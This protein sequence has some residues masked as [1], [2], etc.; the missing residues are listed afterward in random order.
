MENRI[1]VSKRRLRAV[2]IIAV[3]FV[4]LSAAI[5][6]KSGEID[7]LDSDATWHTLLTIEAYNETPIT[8]HLFLP[9]ISLG[10][11]TDKNI[12]WGATVSDRVGNYY[13]T[14]F[15]PA[16]YFLPWL[17]IKCFRLGVTEKSLYVFNTFLL[18]L[19]TII[20]IR[21]LSRVYRKSKYKELLC[22]V[23]SITYIF[24]PEI[25]H[26]MGIVYWHQSVLQVTL[27]MQILAYYEYTI[28]EDHKYKL[29]FFAMA[30]VNPYTE[31]TGYVANIGFAVAEL[32]RNRRHGVIKSFIEPIKIGI[33]TI[34][35]FL[36]F[37][38]HYLFRID[39]D[40]FLLA[41]K[42]RFMARNITTNVALTD[43]FGGYYK[44][45]LFVWILLLCFVVW[46]FI[47]NKRLEISNGLLILV[48]AF[49]VLENIIM[50][51]HA[52]AYTY[53]RMKAAFVVIF[54]LCEVIR[55]LLEYSETVGHEQHLIII[56]VVACAVLNLQS[57]MKDEFY[58]WRTDY[59]EDNEMLA[60]YITEQYPNA[61]YASNGAVRGYMNLLWGRGIYEGQTLDLACGLATSQNVDKVVYINASGYK[62]TE[63]IACDLSDNS[64]TD[65]LVEEHKIRINELIPGL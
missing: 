49:P 14:S 3:V 2:F 37:S 53:D 55:N 30:L 38:V 39:A 34:L 41:L 48:M 52:V 45:F 32:I 15:S 64:K 57:Y 40:V 12:P 33:V 26:G 24:V 65:Y 1:D 50:K 54:I 17:F 5:R 58:I 47:K 31:W 9:I 6:Y 29:I 35:S 4:I 20:W 42:N 62:V 63:V 43:V 28:Q 21:L 22:L 7:Y 51:Q 16:G 56:L 46:N 27:I 13:Y 36:I 19:S 61:L 18:A 44:S 11:A 8:Q 59:K 10:K 23:G 25:L 60:K